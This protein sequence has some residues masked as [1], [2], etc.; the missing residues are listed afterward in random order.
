MFAA[1]G[2]QGSVPVNQ[3]IDAGLHGSKQVKTDYYKVCIPGMQSQPDFKPCPY[4]IKTVSTGFH[5]YRP[6]SYPVSIPNGFWE[7]DTA[8]KKVLMMFKIFTQISI[9]YWYPYWPCSNPIDPVLNALTRINPHCKPCCVLHCPSCNGLTRSY[10][11]IDTGRKGLKRIENGFLYGLRRAK[12]IE[13]YQNVSSVL[14]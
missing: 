10:I 9:L 6:E 11:R 4:E 14:L 13:H 8:E 7:Y 3:E 2:W 5:P 12:N 1:A